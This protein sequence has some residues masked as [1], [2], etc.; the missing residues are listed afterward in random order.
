[1]AGTNATFNI[2]YSFDEFKR[3]TANTAEAE[4]P[5]RGRMR[6]NLRAFTEQ[7]RKYLLAHPEV[8]KAEP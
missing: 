4:A 7:R 6:L 3:A 2:L 8:K 1:M 5:Q